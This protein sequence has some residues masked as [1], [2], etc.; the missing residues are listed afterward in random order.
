MRRLSL[1]GVMS[2]VLSLLFV[3]NGKEVLHSA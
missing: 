3:I 1:E 2:D